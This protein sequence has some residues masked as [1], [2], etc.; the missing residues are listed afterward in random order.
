MKL[1]VTIRTEITDKEHAVM[2]LETI[3]A[4]L[5]IGLDDGMSVTIIDT[6]KN[7]ETSTAEAEK[8][9]PTK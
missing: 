7:P 1:V 8:K 9:H 6:L 3:R 5:P 2:L 4:T